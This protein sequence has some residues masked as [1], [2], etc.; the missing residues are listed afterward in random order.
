MALAKTL[1]KAGAERGILPGQEN[2]VV[3]L[4]EPEPEQKEEGFVER[5][6]K[7]P[8]YLA[9]AATQGWNNLVMAVNGQKM[10]EYGDLINSF[11]QSYTPQQIAADPK[12]AAELEERKRL[13]AELAVDNARRQKENEALLQS[14]R[15]A[16]KQ[17]MGVGQQNRDWLTTASDFGKAIVK[18]PGAFADLIIS[19]GPGSLATAATAMLAYYSTR[20][21]NLAATVGGG[22]SAAIE[23]GNDYAENRSNGMS[24]NEAW[25]KAFLKAFPVGFFDA[26]SMRSAGHAMDAILEAA[27]KGATKTAL[28]QVGKET[29][30]QAGY[31]GA[32]EALGEVGAGEDLNPTNIL[33]EMVA[34]AGGA[35]V[36]A[37]STRGMLHR[38][39]QPSALLARAIAEDVASTRFT[40]AAIEEEARHALATG[41]AP[42][43]L[44]ELAKEPLTKP[45]PPEIKPKD[46]GEPRIG[47]T[48]VGVGGG[49]QEPRLGAAEEKEEPPGIPGVVGEGDLPPLPTG[50]TEEE[51]QTL[52]EEAESRK[53]LADAV[54]ARYPAGENT[55][56]QVAKTNVGHIAFLKDLDAD[57]IV[58]GSARI[59]SGPDSL[60]KAQ[61]HAQGQAQASIPA[62]PAGT[63]PSAPPAPGNQP[64]IGDDFD[65]VGWT[66][67]ENKINNKTGKPIQEEGRVRYKK[68]DDRGF[69]QHV[70]VK[71]GKVIASSSFSPVIELT[72][73]WLN[74]DEP[75]SG[76]IRVTDSEVQGLMLT[77]IPETSSN[78][79]VSEMS[80]R[81]IQQYKDGVPIEQIAETEFSNSGGILPDGS[82][83]PHTTTATIKEQPKPGAV[84]KRV[85]EE[86]PASP[87]KRAPQLILQNRDR[88]SQASQEQMQSIARNPDYDRV[89][90]SNTPDGAPIVALGD[91]PKDQLGRTSRVTAA[92][93]TKIPVQ[94]AVVEAD[95]IITSNDIN[96]AADKRYG[97]M[98]VP[99]LRAIAGNG[100]VTG[101]REAYRRGKAG[102]YRQA[103]ME[104]DLHQVDPAVIARM[105]NPVLVRLMPDSLLTP[106]IGDELN[107]GAMLELSPVEQAKTDLNRVDFDTLEFNEDGE[108][109]PRAVGQFINAMPMEERGKLTDRGL[110]TKQAY[111]RLENAIF[112]RA[113]QDDG[114]I[115]LF[116]QAKDP[117]SRL[118][119]NAL[120]Q[121]AP[122]MARLEGTG[123]LDIRGIVTDA[124]KMIISGRRRGLTL[125]VIVS[126]IDMTT[127][128]DARIIVQLFA[129]NPR[130]NKAAVEALTNAANI[131]YQEANK[132]DE[133]LFGPEE[134]I[135]REELLAKLG[136]QNEPQT[137]ENAEGAGAPAGNVEG[138]TAPSA[139][140]VSG[141]GEEFTLTGETEEE[142]RAK[143][144]AE[145]ERAKRKKKEEEEAEQRAKAREEEFVLT[146]SERPV[147]EAAARGQEELDDQEAEKAELSETAQKWVN[148]MGSQPSVEAFETSDDIQVKTTTQN[149]EGTISRQEFDELS[150]EAVESNQKRGKKY[151]ILIH[152]TPEKFAVLTFTARGITPTQQQVEV[153]MTLQKSEKVSD[154]NETGFRGASEPAY[155]PEQRAKAEV[156]AK[157]F[158]GE[159]AWQ[160]GDYS[161][162]RGY[163][164]LSGDPVYVPTKL[165]Q[166]AL[167][168][169]EDYTGNLVPED[170]KAR[171]IEAKKRLEKEAED[172]HRTA[173]FL[174]LDSGV[175][176]S[177]DIP[178]DL[179]GV[180]R[181]WKDLLKLDAPIYVS[182]IDDA[183]ANKN[184]FTGPHRRIGSG[185][186]DPNWLG[187]MRRMADGSYY[188]LF[189]QSTSPTLM[190]ET[191][192]HEMGHVHQ[193]LYFENA[194]PEEKRAL[195]A[196]H[197][198]W[199]KEQKGKTAKEYIG[200]LRARMT[201]R[202]PKPSAGMMASEMTPYWR[203]FGEWYADQV[204]RWAMSAERPVSVVEKFF[205]RLGMQLRKFYQQLKNAKY[206]PNETFAKYIEAAT[207]RPA[208]LEPGSNETQRMETITPRDPEVIRAEKISEYK[209][210]R[211]RIAQIPKRVAEGKI[212]PGDQ[213]MTAWLL[214]KAQELKQ[215]I[216]L[217]KPRQDSPEKFLAKAL[218]EYDNGNISDEVLAVIKAAYDRHPDLL[219]GLLLS[220]RAPKGR[221]NAAGAFGSMSRIVYLYKGTSGVLRPQTVRHELAHSM[222]QMMT[223]EQRSVII[224]QWAK[225]LAKAINNNP[226]EKYQKYFKA[227]LDYIEDPSDRNY[228]K[229]INALPSYEM[230]QFVSPS[231]YWAVNAEPLMA[232]ELGSSWDRFKSAM[233][234]LWEG[235]KHVF[236]VD[237]R[238]AV[239]RTFQKIMSGDKQRMGK[240]TLGDYVNSLGIS[241]QVL[242]NIDDD[243][244]L[245]KRY[246][247]PHTAQLNMAPVANA[248]KRSAVITKDAFKLAVT[249]PKKALG[250]TKDGIEN[251]FIDARIGTTW[252]GGGLEARDFDAY[253]GQLQI[254]KNLA[255][256]SVALDNAI[257]S[258]NIA[259]E[260]LFRGG[261]KFDSRFHNFISV[262][263]EKGMHG[264]YRAEIALKRKIG[265]QLGTDIIQGYLEAK[266]SISIMNELYDREQAAQYAEDD[267]AVLKA[268]KAPVADI[269][270]AKEAL[271]VA[272]EELA[273]VQGAVNSVNM[274]DA[275]MYEFAAYEH[276]Y[277]ELREIMDN[278]AA[279]NQ[280]LLRI[281]R[282]VGLI[283]QERYDRLSKIQDYVPWNRVMVDEEDVS[284]PIL[285]TTRSL[286]NIGR[287]KKFTKGRPMNVIDF[288]AKAGQTVFK[289]QPSSVV[290]VEVNGIPVAPM[291]VSV[292]PNGEVKLNTTIAEGD[293]VVFSTHREI[294]NIIDNMTRTVMRMTI[295]AIR[296]YAATRI[297]Q[298]YA[299]RDTHGRLMVYPKVDTEKG[300]FQF[301]AAGKKIVVEIPDSRVAAAIYGMQNIDLRM[302][303]PFAA[304]A[305]FSRRAITLS[306]WFQFRQ[307]FKDAPTAAIVTGVRN[308]IALIIGSYIHLLRGLIQPGVKRLTGVDVDPTMTLLRRGGIGGFYS[309][310][311]TP[312]AEIKRRLGIMN[313][314][315]YH[316]VI[317]TLD[318]I[319][320]VSDAS[321]RAAV[322]DRIMKE[323]GDSTRAW[324]QAANVINFMHHGSHGAAQAIVKTVPFTGAF[325]NATDVLVRS[326]LGVNLRGQSRARAFAQLSATLP[327]LVGLSM[328]YC[329][330]VGADPDYDE[331]D[332][333][334]K[335]RNFLIPGT[336]IK[337]DISTSAAAIYKMIPEL[338]YNKVTRE[339]TNNEYDR[340]R[341]RTA[342]RDIAIDTLLGPEPIPSAIKPFLEISL[343]R[344]FRTDTNI[345]P[346]N[347]EGV[348]AA[349]Q[350]NARTSELA[351]IFSGLTEV[352]GTDKRLLN[353]MEADHLI[354]ALFGAAGSM[355]QWISNSLSKDR[356]EP[357]AQESP[358]TGQFLRG[359]VPRGNEVLYYDF[360]KEVEEKYKTFELLGKRGQTEEMDKYI[361]KHGDVAAM[362]Q[363]I[364][365]VDKTLQEI[366]NAEKFYGE[367]KDTGMTPHE[368]RKELEELQRIRQ[369]VLSS[370]KEMRREAGL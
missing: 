56:W 59:W 304:A 155:T 100:R 249:D 316:F 369:E 161:L 279:I 310:A 82:L 132:P 265:D 117:E 74:F 108:I 23:F 69:E 173:P 224:N 260:V 160:E 86:K 79:I 240:M 308:P 39:S 166:H 247:R 85:E 212:G 162:I 16:T 206:L 66:E 319:G 53:R 347:L 67:K 121:V 258:N 251:M 231:E 244:D 314:N 246:S 261:L 135:S 237:N 158:G 351:K 200:A 98:S 131:A 13:F 255:V 18:D 270:I 137:V 288:K 203:S 209:S 277:G 93:G 348:E 297:V 256:A 65:P 34:E 352:P 290:S 334:T 219:N 80:P 9:S 184:N 51:K 287:E 37:V 125:P 343:N 333:Q 41:Q 138:E 119:I 226:D 321:T 276:K 354:R 329:M 295:N 335:L 361:E 152:D 92:S 341:L 83:T 353:P 149:F 296:Q 181:G 302:F 235:L 30:W 253:K 27:E 312:E 114:L 164:A 367:S 213:N 179:A 157:A 150:K 211:Q 250:A 136:K 110:P 257:R 94:Y 315:I 172:K 126:Q 175:V 311:R 47:Q 10:S 95:D 325:L 292:T 68:L 11:R 326:L 301:I 318:Y 320:D 355:A 306:A 317:K 350:Y 229:A 327:T 60:E 305:N 332:D 104:D 309:P 54:V 169:I 128:P 142:I 174:A 151:S 122:V 46:R 72:N 263:R 271:K 252:Y 154:E 63:T 197:E 32:G 91:I 133:G 289:I 81:A 26:L 17:M 269:E 364:V 111:Q 15:P 340:R 285:A 43:T 356:P 339:G 168:D 204:S 7:E 20:N 42:R 294:E 360:K 273:N 29:L 227:V 130:S 106:T 6:K 109:T 207:Q 291:D 365:D 323:T 362:H 330:L 189:H 272:K 342:L 346:Q 217:S 359:E 58:P 307:V 19:S 245:L 331:L 118:L 196:E 76:R 281:W 183:R 357:T 221:G 180:I 101:I 293:L 146:G 338:I 176:L 278:W 88:S 75:V 148:F 163:S 4:P 193:R 191:I 84:S 192:A 241:V 145:K 205:K 210:L 228:K 120:M 216:E 45:E 188:I 275:E 274:S 262:E 50:N 266:R 102:G 198:K 201:A 143:K 182:T 31:G 167:V 238:F 218:Q 195:R 12:L 280:N 124:A 28:K 177:K 303:A 225:S 36:E 283:S 40:R 170:V 113:Y 284:S 35:P 147:D 96:G 366:H 286:T 8:G 178:S 38:E 345:T 223:P 239:H 232:A 5:L 337:L 139:A 112:A 300:R 159:I 194:T 230:Y 115:A 44:E 220:V 97:D 55:E 140:G 73:S 185:T 208:N 61:E 89:G 336:K 62:A 14:A 78:A 24:H 3:A 90:I 57:E 322:Y 171:M 202:Q 144:V 268:A 71:D 22:G 370:V 127:D 187:S 116:A 358:M 25:K 214:R 313:F 349:Q 254:S 299:T 236:G 282:D 49:R 107:R 153:S 105:E 215:A 242:E 87:E 33:A 64:R 141:S 328:L 134:K 324:H 123:N 234:Q 199:L 363:Y 77:F 70:L 52:A 368:R 1:G 248:I 267:L 186:L 129:A 103:M 233:R 48:P 2:K 222:E 344:N 298:E 259:V 99:G 190:L 264:V 21:P 165:S 243:K 156:H